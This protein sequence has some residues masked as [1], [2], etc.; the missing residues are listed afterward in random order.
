MPLP[1]GKRGVHTVSAWRDRRASGGGKFAD[2]GPPA[3]LVRVTSQ[4][5]AMQ[6]TGWF[7]FRGHDASRFSS[8]GR[9]TDGRR[10]ESSGVV[11]AGR[12]PRVWERLQF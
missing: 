1:K 5:G 7:K 9:G 10:F 8:F 2:Q 12:S 3:R 6:S 11:F 4:T